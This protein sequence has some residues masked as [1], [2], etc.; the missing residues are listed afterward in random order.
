MLSLVDT[1]IF[2]DWW[3]FGL[4]ALIGFIVKVDELDKDKNSVYQNKYYKIHWGWLVVTLLLAIIKGALVL[5][6]TYVII[7]IKIE[8]PTL[9]VVGA[10]IVTMSFDSVWHY[11]QRRTLCHL[12]R[13]DISSSSDD[14]F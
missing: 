9:A 10:G 3:M 12:N 2:K 11:V 1:Q 4:G 13:R 8:D 14:L 6:G 7:R 5:V